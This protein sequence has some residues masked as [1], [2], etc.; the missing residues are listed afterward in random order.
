MMDI[1]IL[2]I[3]RTD[4]RI[5]NSELSKKIGLSPGP[6]LERTKKLERNGVITGYYAKM[7]AKKI[8]YGIQTFVEVVLS[9]HKKDNIIEFMEA[10]K[11]V[12]EI[13][14]CYHITGKSDF[15]LK[16]YVENIQAYED[17]LLH[18]LST[19]PGLQHVETFIVMRCVKNEPTPPVKGS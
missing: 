6:T 7:D 2:N 5:A 9:R 11:A 4:G 19:L 3:L 1:M 18:T 12:P 13:I 15:L 10:V 16:V 14:G 8:G 17:F